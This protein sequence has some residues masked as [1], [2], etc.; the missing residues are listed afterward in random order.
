MQAY[1][2]GG[3]VRDALLGLPVKDRD[4]VVVGSTPEE[5]LARGFRPVGRDFPVFLHPHTSEEYALART[6]RK[7]GR[8]YT[9]F[10]CHASPEVTLEEDLLRRDLTINAI[11]RT[12]DGTL[13]DPYG[14][15][16]D[17]A[18]RL[19][20]HVSP[21]FAEDPLRILRVAR[22]A[23]RFTDFTV[24]PETLALMQQMVGAG[25]VDHLVAERVWQEFARGLMEA[26]P[27]RMIRVLRDCG[28]LAVI[29]PELDRL[30]GIPQPEKYHPEIDTGEHVLMVV[31][32]AAASAQ[33]LAVRWACLLH[34]L[35]K[36]DT[37]AH[38]LPHHY[39]HEAA[40]ARRA[41]AVSERLKAPTDCR[42]LAEMVAREHGILARAEALRPETMVKL[43]ERC[44]GLRRPERFELMLQAA[45][46]DH[47][48]R[49]GQ[50]HGDWRPLSHWRAAL[51]AVRAI[52][53]ATI[54]RSCSDKKHIP[55]AL[56]AARVAAVK[57]RNKDPK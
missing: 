36:G 56:H 38:V 9:G 12:E 54:A 26:R 52:D 4:W 55:D 40:S 43:I 15:Q 25:E 13:I 23:A 33:P 17:L 34:D 18:A 49:G 47:A 29:L 14:G 5:M 28:A 1:V 41:R 46:C 35:G 6:E 53:A 19:F 31:D 39:G 48:G 16:R 3:A 27:A 32:A 42:D 21:A 57:A 8:G 37:P 44:D 2:V 11:A 45:A 51:A 50:T 22:F 24:A 20:R 7:S 30:F 10:V